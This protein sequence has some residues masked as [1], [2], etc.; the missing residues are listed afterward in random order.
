ME[1]LALNRTSQHTTGLVDPHSSTSAPNPLG[2]CH[3]SGATSSISGSLATKMLTPSSIANQTLLSSFPPTRAASSSTH[4]PNYPS[5]QRSSNQRS[6]G[7]QGAPFQE[8][9]NQGT[10][11][12]YPSTNSKTVWQTDLCSSKSVAP[13]YPKAALVP[14]NSLPHHQVPAF[15]SHATA[16]RSHSQGSLNRNTASS[17]HDVDIP[18]SGGFPHQGPRQSVFGTSGAPP[19]S[20]KRKTMFQEGMCNTLS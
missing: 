4:V 20:L 7:H 16:N 14:P 12:R 6:P 10:V 19:H 3:P 17:H 2:S 5:C 13:P 9:P 15:A 18:R 11:P 8:M 1:T